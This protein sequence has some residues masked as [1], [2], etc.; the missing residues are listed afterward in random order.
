MA[1]GQ[2]SIPGEGNEPADGEVVETPEQ[3]LARLRAENL[4]LTTAAAE[5]DKLPQAVYE[6]ETPHGKANLA[7]SD[8]ATMT[9]AQVMAA[10]DAGK[11]KEPVNSYLC[12][13]GYYSRR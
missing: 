4:A 11:L 9:V 10:I 3:E 2:V 8:T 5:R 7:A 13:D 6:P 1:R 12:A